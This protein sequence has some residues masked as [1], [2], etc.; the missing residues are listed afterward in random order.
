VIARILSVAYD[1]SRRLV[2][3]SQF[4]GDKDGYSNRA[5]IHVFHIS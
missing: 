1:P 4:K 3:V 5:L 2:Y